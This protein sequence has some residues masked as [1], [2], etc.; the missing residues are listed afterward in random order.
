MAHPASNTYAVMR[1]QRFLSTRN[2]RSGTA[3]FVD[4]MGSV[5]D[6]FH[7]PRGR[8]IRAFAGTYTRSTSVNAAMAADWDVIAGDMRAA[9]AE[10][11]ATFKE[12]E[13]PEL[14]ASL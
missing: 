10:H 7:A 11:D 13:T 3:A 8:Y 12:E 14:A 2:R 5:I 9:I 1:M 6:L 4:G